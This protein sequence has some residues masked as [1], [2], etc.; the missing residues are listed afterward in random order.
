MKNVIR[1]IIFLLMSLQFA[2]AQ[3]QPASPLKKEYYQIFLDA[4][5]QKVN[6][7]NYFDDSGSIEF[8]LSP[9]GK[10]IHLLN[11][12]GEG[13]VKA[14]VVNADGAVEEVVRSKCKIHSLQEL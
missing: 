7:V 9:D 5:V 1:V 8:K 4:P 6:K 2:H 11:Y 14:E 10:A 3:E 12:K 13:G